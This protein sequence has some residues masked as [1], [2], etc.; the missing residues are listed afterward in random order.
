[1]WIGKAV[2]VTTSLWMERIG[3]TTRIHRI[4][5][6][7]RRGNIEEKR[8]KR[9]TGRGRWIGLGRRGR[10]VEHERRRESFQRREKDQYGDVDWERRRENEHGRSRGR[11]EEIDRKRQKETDLSK[12]KN[13]HRASDRDR[14][15]ER[16][17]EKD[18]DMYMEMDRV[19]DHDCGNEQERERQ[20]DRD[21]EKSR[22]KSDSGK[23]YN[24]N[25]NSFGQRRDN[26]KRD[27]HEQDDF[28]ERIALKLAEQEEEDLNRIKEESRRRREAILE[29]YRNQ[30]LQQKNE[31]RSEDADKDKELIE[32][33]G[34]SAVTNNVAPETLDGRTDGAMLLRHHFLWGNHL[35]KTEYK[36]LLRGLQVLQDL[37][38][39]LQSVRDQM[40]NIVMI[41]L[42][43]HPLEL[44]N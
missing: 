40:K 44:V 36:L 12:H 31:S 3:I 10:E 35:H 5:R 14:E 42:E 43:R 7:A 32:G 20:N 29:K 15:R 24:F 30:Q 17:R 19:R 6:G 38:K 27:E 26:L 4:E 21:R 37:E 11:V 34:N 18:R 9:D 23:F 8:N 13:M 1:M 16:E 22:D 28:E 39:V 41:F 33:P 25:S 2:L